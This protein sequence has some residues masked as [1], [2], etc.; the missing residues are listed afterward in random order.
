M[1]PYSWLFVVVFKKH[2]AMELADKNCVGRGVWVDWGR[3][4]RNAIN[5]SFILDFS[6]NDFIFFLLQKSMGATHALFVRDF[7]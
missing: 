5:V 1:S 6:G 2:L 7:Y 4:R 3:D